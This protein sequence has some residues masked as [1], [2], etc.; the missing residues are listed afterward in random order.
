MS[1]PIV[2]PVTVDGLAGFTDDDRFVVGEPDRLGRM[3][4]TSYKDVRTSKCT[5]CGHGWEPTSESLRDQ[6]YWELLRVGPGGFC[7]LSPDQALKGA[8]H[9]RNCH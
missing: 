1:S 3:T 9:A 7:G 6:T 4:Y 2:R 5:I 8:S